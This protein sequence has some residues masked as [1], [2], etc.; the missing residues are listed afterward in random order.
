MKKFYAVVG[1]EE[2]I[3]LDRTFEDAVVT[4]WFWNI[5]RVERGELEPGEKIHVT[6]LALAYHQGLIEN[7]EVSLLPVLNGED[8]RNELRAYLKK[9]PTQKTLDAVIA[10]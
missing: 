6:E 1:D 8:L 3:I 4:F 2:Y 10:G 7:A 5:M 9:P